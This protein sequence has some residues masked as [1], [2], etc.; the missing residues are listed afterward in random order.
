[1]SRYGVPG[2]QSLDDCS[3]ATRK[4]YLEVLNG[5]ERVIKVVKKGPPTLIFRRLAKA[6]RVIFESVPLDQKHVLIGIFDA[7]LQL[8]R[9]ISVHRRNYGLRVGE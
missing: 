1:L 8:R 2:D 5:W 7:P 3:A 9:N 4:H 6:N